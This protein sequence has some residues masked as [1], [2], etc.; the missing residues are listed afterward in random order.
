[1]GKS[2]RVMV[3][4]P[5]V[6]WADVEFEWELPRPQPAKKKVAPA[7]I[8]PAKKQLS[9]KDRNRRR[10][11][12]RYRQ[13]RR[14]KQVAKQIKELARLVGFDLLDIRA[15]S[16]VENEKKWRE[17]QQR[18]AKAYAEKF[19]AAFREA[20]RKEAAEKTAA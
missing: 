3:L 4:P 1:M 5:D 2:R 18:E 10:K 6:Q 11:I 15:D 13:R 16:F 19:S 20:V 8:V 14:E 9:A 12:Q 17:Q 7:R